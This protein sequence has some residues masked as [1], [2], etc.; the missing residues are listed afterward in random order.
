MNEKIMKPPIEHGSLSRR[1]FLGVL[2]GSSL[3]LLCP[4]RG[5]SQTSSPRMRRWFAVQKVMDEHVKAGK[6]AGAVAAL[7][8]DGAP[9]TYEAAAARNLLPDRG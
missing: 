6:I 5:F 2:T 7:S 1:L 8:H 3:P 4:L 9:V